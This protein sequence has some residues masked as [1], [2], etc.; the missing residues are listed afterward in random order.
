LKSGF[1]TILGRPNVG[2]ST[3]LNALLGEKISIVTNKPQTTRELIK[4]ILTREDFQLVFLDTPG[5]HAP[6]SKLDEF[7]NKNISA[8]LTD[9]DLV[10][11]MT[12]PEPPR[13]E[14]AELV[15]KIPNCPAILIINKIDL[16]QKFAATNKAELIVEAYKKLRDFDGVVLMSATNSK[17]VADLLEKIKR[18]IPDGPQYYDAEE[19]S[20]RRE[21][22]IVADIIREK[23]LRVMR[24]EIPH[25][26]AVEITSMK[27]RGD[28]AICDIEA[29]IFCE[30]AS[31]KGMII[32]KNGAVLKTAGSRAREDIERFLGEKV[33]LQLFVKL[34]KDWRNN[35]AYLK[36]LGYKL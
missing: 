10:L 29:N 6:K 14:V 3:L 11:F 36:D 7:M 35:P 20:D 23:I 17:D 4:G 34:R 32:G 26:V 31:H 1:I 22:D 28:K 9:A 30:K 12:E 18:Y 24:D 19:I 8:A 27:T 2:K 13:A 25:G 21:R 33:F 5:F 16:I 15:K